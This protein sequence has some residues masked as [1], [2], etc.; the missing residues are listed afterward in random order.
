MR[1]LQGK[2]V[3][4]TGASRGIGVPIA[5]ALAKRGAKVVLS[6]RDAAGLADTAA[7]VQAAGGFA[8]IVPGDVTSEADQQAL[9]EA[10]RVLGPIEGVV[11]NAGIETTLAFA[12][13]RPDEISRQIAVN[14]DAPLRLAHLVLPGLLAQDRGFIVFM[15]S[16]S[17]KTST[18]FNAVYTATKHGLVGFT[19]SLRIELQGTGVHAGVVCPGFVD[20]AGMWASQGLQAPAMMQAV[21]LSAVVDATLRAID[22]AGEVLVTK[23]P[24]R[25]LLA[26]AQLFPGLEGMVLDKMGILS[27]LRDR[28]RVA[29]EARRR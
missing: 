20:E 14:L 7:K 23:T 2:V 26:I 24:V 6:A 28:A 4:L 13:Q 10:A 29:A 19:S 25:P 1:D 18:P 12:D 9:V 21:P 3:I 15:S 16:M 27:T 5:V 22:G 8:H 17:G 11:C